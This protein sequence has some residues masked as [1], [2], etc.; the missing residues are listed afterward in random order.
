MFDHKTL[1]VEV[2]SSYLSLCYFQD[3]KEEVWT[4]H[5]L[6]L[7]NAGTIISN[8]E[9]KKQSIRYVNTVNIHF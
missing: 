5:L 9:I 8:L 2:F 4:E 6:S 3:K 7:S 1:V